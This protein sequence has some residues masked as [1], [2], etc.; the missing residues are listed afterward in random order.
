MCV[1]GPTPH[2]TDISTPVPLASTG[3]TEI[4]FQLAVGE[5]TA[6]G[7]K[8]GWGL[9]PQAFLS[10]SLLLFRTYR[11]T[12]KLSFPFCFSCMKA[13]PTPTP[14]ATK[15]RTSTMA[16]SPTESQTRSPSPTATQLR[17]LSQTITPTPTE[18]QTLCRTPT[19]SS[20]ATPTPTPSFT[21]K[22]KHTFFSGD[23][24]LRLIFFSRVKALDTSY[25]SRRVG[26]LRCCFGH[27]GAHARQGSLRNRPLSRHLSC[28]VL[29]PAAAQLCCS[30]RFSGVFTVSEFV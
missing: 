15:R 20:T 10:T 11:C 28:G 26:G 9:G 25:I 13:T 21:R 4:F 22:R 1:G 7:L 3:T 16:A 29:Y 27:V 8:E 6:I 24:Y 17:T 5:R 14:T 2:Y 18:T 30:R 19:S 23:A 12:Q